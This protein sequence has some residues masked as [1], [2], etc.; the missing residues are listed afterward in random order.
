MKNFTSCSVFKNV[1]AGKDY[2]G[3][4]HLIMVKTWP[5]GD[6]ALQIHRSELR[7]VCVNLLHERL[8]SE[9]YFSNVSISI[10]PK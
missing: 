1:I 8:T 6:V 10:K 5:M 2:G 9:F 3:Q 4:M 7:N